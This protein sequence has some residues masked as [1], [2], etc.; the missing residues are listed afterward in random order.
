MLVIV[1][2]TKLDLKIR[3]L[4]FISSY[5]VISYLNGLKL[6]ARKFVQEKLH[7]VLRDASETKLEVPFVTIKTSKF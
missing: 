4:F 7:L 5:Y 3:K 1:P 6:K 2:L